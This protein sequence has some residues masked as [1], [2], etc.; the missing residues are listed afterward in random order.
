[1]NALPYDSSYVLIDPSSNSTG[2]FTYTSSDPTIIE[3]SGNVLTVVG[4]SGQVTLTAT[5]AA[6]TNYLS[7]STQM[8][9]T[10]TA[11]APTIDILT[12]NNPDLSNN[13]SVGTLYTIIDPSSNSTGLFTYTSD[14][15]AVAFV[16]GNDI[17]MNMVGTANISGTQASSSDNHY[18]TGTVPVLNIT[19]Q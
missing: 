17:S 16:S 18:S 4:V 11:I 13:Q 19:V 3:V 12:T 6:T 1:M 15:T 14:N 8:F 7:G 5:Q 10:Q 9:L 2:A